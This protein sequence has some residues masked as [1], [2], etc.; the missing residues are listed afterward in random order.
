MTMRSRPPR[1]GVTEE[2]I[3]K[4]GEVICDAVCIPRAG[5]SSFRSDSGYTKESERAL[6]EP[7]APAVSGVSGAPPRAA[8]APAA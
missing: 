3:E 8:A 7:G 2:V 5:L 6:V 1:G 4:A